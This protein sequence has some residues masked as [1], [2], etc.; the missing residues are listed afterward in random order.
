MD[1][2]I[3]SNFSYNSLK[4]LHDL[5]EKIQLGW[6]S[7]L[8]EYRLKKTIS[9][10]KFLDAGIQNIHPLHH[11]V[12]KPFLRDA[13]QCGLKIFPWTINSKE[14][15]IKMKNDYKVDGIISNFPDLMEKP[16][17]FNPATAQL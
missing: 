10:E 8:S 2:V 4:I 17:N 12:S 11:S 9:C 6:I 3:L 1:Y 14:I 13:R 7:K 15:A 5:D 16:M